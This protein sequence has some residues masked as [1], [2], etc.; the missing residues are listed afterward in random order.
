MSFC[1]M[2]FPQKRLSSSINET[3]VGQL[4]SDLTVS[5]CNVPHEQQAQLEQKKKIPSRP[6]AHLQ[7]VK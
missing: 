1:E 5:N 7:A 3:T 2:C 6:Q 4:D